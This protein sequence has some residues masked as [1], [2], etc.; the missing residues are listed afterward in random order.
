MY[1]RPGAHRHAQ[2]ASN[3]A[4]GG[5][6]SMLALGQQ[7][8]QKRQQQLHWRSPPP[9]VCRLA[10][11]LA[12]LCGNARH[13]R[14]ELALQ[15]AAWPPPCK[16]ISGAHLLASAVQC[17]A[18]CEPTNDALTSALRYVTTSPG[19]RLKQPVKRASRLL[20]QQHKPSSLCGCLW[21]RLQQGAVR[22]ETRCA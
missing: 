8:P 9:P 11:W 4:K 17:G 14:I 21:Y 7:P 2:T 10:A 20:Q 18:A 13:R 12:E 15:V 22:R 3:E 19:T 5:E 16:R 6:G 1:A